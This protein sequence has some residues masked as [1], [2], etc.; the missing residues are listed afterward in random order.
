VKKIG[1][2]LMDHGW[3]IQLFG[4]VV[5]FASFL[6]IVFRFINHNFYFF[7]IATPMVAIG[8]ALYIIGRISVIFH[9]R[10]KKNRDYSEEL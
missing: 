6:L 4:F 5:V 8:I 10:S 1:K 7:K 3:T 2:I 9:N